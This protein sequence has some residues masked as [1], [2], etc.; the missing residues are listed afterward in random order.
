MVHRDTFIN[1]IR[2]LRYT[3]KSQQL[4]TQ[5]W[6]KRGGTHVIFVPLADLLEED[7]V[8]GVLRQAGVADQEIKLFIAS[9]KT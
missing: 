6:R 5:L 7:W 8:T 9:V 2:E 4:R 1:R 3:Y